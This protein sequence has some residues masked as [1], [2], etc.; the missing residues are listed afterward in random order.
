MRQVLF[1]WL[2]LGIATSG[3][4]QTQWVLKKNSNGIKV[5]ESMSSSSRFKS[6]K[7]DAVLEG[8]LKKLVDILSDVS[9][10]TKWVYS[11]KKSYLIEKISDNDLVYYAETA[12]PWPF[13]NRDQAI[14]LKIFPPS[15]DGLTKITT[16]GEPDR[17]PETDGKVRIRN[18]LGTWIVQPVN[19]HQLHI[20]YLLEVDPSGSIPPW[21]MNLFVTKGPFETFNKLG[22]LMAQ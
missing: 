9:N 6:V 21:L 11:T 15:P 1:I 2:I 3:F 12:I 10:N 20:D 16:T 4:S 18:F 5:F 22:E 19:D 8:T 7:V 17:I 14:H 13:R